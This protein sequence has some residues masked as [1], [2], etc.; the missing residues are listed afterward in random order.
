MTCNPSPSLSAKSLPRGL[1]SPQQWQLLEWMHLA[2]QIE[3]EDELQGFLQALLEQAP[4][5]RMA[6]ALGRIDERRQIQH[7]ERVFNINYP[8]SWQQQYLHENYACCDP[9]LRTPLDA[10]PQPW[11][12]RFRN[13][14]RVEERRFVNEASLAGMRAGMCFGAHSDRQRLGCLLSLEGEEASRDPEMVAM[15]DCLAPHLYQAAVRVALLPPLSMPPVALSQRESDIFLWM[16]RGKTNWEIAAILDISERT[17]KFHVAN[18]IHKLGA[19]N[20]THAIV[21]GMRCGLTHPAAANE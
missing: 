20:R 7:L 16:S 13:L 19:N 12:E 2:N 5:L 3:T 10:G 4:S 6:L 15:L 21:L 1:S 17:V 14:A 18:V 11:A 9:V 8:A